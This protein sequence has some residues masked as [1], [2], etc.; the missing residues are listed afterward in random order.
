MPTPTFKFTPLVCPTCSSRHSA[1]LFDP[2]GQ[3]RAA[4]CGA[5]FTR[6][7]ED[8][9]GKRRS[10][11]LTSFPRLMEEV[12]GELEDGETASEMEGEGGLSGSLGRVFGV[13]ISV[14]RKGRGRRDSV[15]SEGTAG[16][17]E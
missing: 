2:K 3:R 15:L 11:D 6:W 10:A 1:Q 7:A 12:E 14:F 4:V 17:E 5:C 16:S 13:G 9:A 8:E